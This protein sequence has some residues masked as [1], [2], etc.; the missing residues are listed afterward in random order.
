MT[1]I[2]LIY[3]SNPA[4]QGPYSWFKA[5]MNESVFTTPSNFTLIPAPASGYAIHVMY[6]ALKMT[7]VNALTGGTIAIG[8]S[9]NGTG[10]ATLTKAAVIYRS[11]TSQYLI[12]SPLSSGANIAASAVEGS[13]VNF[14]VTQQYTGS[15]TNSYEWFVVYQTVKI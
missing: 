6:A 3:Q 5:P 7:I 9:Y 2:D 12:Y 4:S 13:S 10:N 11:A 8:L 1:A 14:N 15:G